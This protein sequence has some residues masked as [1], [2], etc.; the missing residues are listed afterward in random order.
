MLLI[1]V[2]NALV[3]VHVGK[4]IPTVNWLMAP[5]EDEPLID[6]TTDNRTDETTDKTNNKITDKATDTITDKMT[7]KINDKITDKIID[8]EAY[9]IDIADIDVDEADVTDAD[10]TE[11]D[12]TDLENTGDALSTKVSVSHTSRRYSIEMIFTM[13]ES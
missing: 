9:M 1:H 2:I 4:I 12:V 10:V 8:S 3:L 13:I 5:A 6:K 7:D 11:A